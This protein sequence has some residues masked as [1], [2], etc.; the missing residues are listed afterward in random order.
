MVLCWYSSASRSLRWRLLLA[1]NINPATRITRTI[2]PATTPAINP[3]R[4]ESEE[5]S[6]LFLDD[7][8][9]TDTGGATELMSPVEVG[10]TVV[11]VVVGSVV[12]AGVVTAVV[13]FGFGSFGSFFLTTV[14][15]A[16]AASAGAAAKYGSDDAC[17]RTRFLGNI[18]VRGTCLLKLRGM[19][20]K[21]AGLEERYVH[22]LS[23]EAFF[24]WFLRE[25]VVMVRSDRVV[26]GKEEEG[27][28]C[29]DRGRRTVC[30]VWWS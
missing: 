1:L 7:P 11:V 22:T 27:C 4:L 29:E 18:R 30:I 2:T 9:G 25:S 20:C 14:G 3:V 24:F 19:V 15:A 12:V 6:D 23:G 13:F 26:G 5:D 21:G 10:T 16:A 28:Q 17:P 8:D